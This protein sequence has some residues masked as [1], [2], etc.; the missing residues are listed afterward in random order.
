MK[1]KDLLDKKKSISIRLAGVTWQGLERYCNNRPYPITKSEAIDRAL[2]F[3]LGGIQYDQLSKLDIPNILADTDH[4]LPAVTSN[5]TITS[6]NLVV[7]TALAK[8]LGIPRNRLI[9]FAIHN[10]LDGTYPDIR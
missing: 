10:L 7:L 5:Y 9:I 2:T 1:R 3:F 8:R 4:S 6:R